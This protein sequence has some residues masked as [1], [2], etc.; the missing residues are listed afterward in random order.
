MS[1]CNFLRLNYVFKRKN[2]DER[3]KVRE[4]ERERDD[5][6]SACSLPNGHKSTSCL[7]LG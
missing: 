3:R 2:Y 5:F 4:R 7:A 1:T 6:P